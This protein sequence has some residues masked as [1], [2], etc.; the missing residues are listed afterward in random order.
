MSTARQQ[1][2]LIGYGNRLRRDDGA[3]RLVAEE[4]AAR[5]NASVT[6]CSVHQLTPELCPLI[7][8]HPAVIF[9]DARAGT[10]GPPCELSVL[11]G[12]ARIA[13]GTHIG[14]PR[15]LL[16]LAAELYDARPRAWCL[17]VPGTDFGLGEGLSAQARNR[18]RSAVD[19]IE[20]LC[21]SLRGSGLP[22]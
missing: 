5:G 12:D 7:A 3:G 14:S 20:G 4:I 6:V 9:V 19:V 17:S 13:W 21:Q 10:D 18:I 8:E 15:A 11:Q 2:L 1:L 22:E 16:A